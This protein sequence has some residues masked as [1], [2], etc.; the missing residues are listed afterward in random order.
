MDLNELLKEKGMSKAEFSRELGVSRSTI[1]EWFAGKYMPKEDKLKKASEVLCVPIEYFYEQGEEAKIRRRLGE[2]AERIETI[3][4]IPVYDVA[5]GEG[6]VNGDHATEYEDF[7]ENGYWCAVHGDSMFPELKDGDRVRVQRQTETAKTDLTV[8][9]VDGEHAT[10]K[11]VEI[12][13]NGVW[14]RA[15]NKEVYEDHFFS[16]SEVMTLPVT[17]IGKVVEVRR[18]Y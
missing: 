11:Y 4:K 14:L 17:I 15:L 1:S 3:R 7:S 6:R 18:T 8:V 10:V 5:A 13:E 9:K 12:V 2:Y 16:I